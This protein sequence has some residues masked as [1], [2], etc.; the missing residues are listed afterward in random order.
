V[1]G[2]LLRA[3]EV[4]IEL[5]RPTVP[6]LRQLL[7]HVKFH[8]LVHRAEREDDVLRLVLDGPAS[9]F[10]QSTRYGLQLATFFP[11]VL[12]QDLP[13]RLEADVRW[14]P[15][16]RPVKLEVGPDL[17]LVSHLADTGA[18]APRELDWFRERFDAADVGPWGL[19]DRVDP[20]ELGGRGVV[21][22]D[23]GLTDGQRTA[24]LEIVGY[25]RK[26]WL[27]RRLEAL[28]RHGPGNL[29]LAVSRKLAVDKTVLTNLPVEVISFSEVIPVKAVLEAAERVAR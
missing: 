20:I 26:D 11:A 14:G 27:L 1:Q 2:I 15:T 22:P 17:G 28:R 8:Q 10:G 18:Y 5:H 21:L 4:R 7:R 13:W 23:V 16:K 12:L 24:W 29:I 25:W 19:T 3:T 9:I 6:R